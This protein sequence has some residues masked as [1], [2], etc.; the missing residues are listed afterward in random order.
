MRPMMGKSPHQGT[1][2]DVAAEV[3][4]DQPGDGERLS[5]A[6]FDGV[7]EVS[8]VHFAG[9]AGAGDRGGG[10]APRGDL[11]VEHEANSRA[12]GDER[13]E[14]QADAEVLVGHALR[15]AAGSDHADRNGKRSAGD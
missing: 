10:V 6:K 12:I 14:L 1:R 4:L 3:V 8:L 5:F 11:G 2:S 13:R 15:R 7:G 9:H